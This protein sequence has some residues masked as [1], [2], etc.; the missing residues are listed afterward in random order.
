[1]AGTARAIMEK[2]ASLSPWKNRQT[3]YLFLPRFQG[4]WIASELYQWLHLIAKFFPDVQV[5]ARCPLTSSPYLLLVKPKDSSPL[6]SFGT[7]RKNWQTHKQMYHLH[8]KMCHSCL[9]PSYNSGK[10]GEWRERW[11]DSQ[12]FGLS[13]VFSCF[14]PFRPNSSMDT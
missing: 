2:Y 4:P 14:S 1:M 11:R 9:I 8:Q 13:E 3:R 12:P 10:E 6:D 5:L 7:R